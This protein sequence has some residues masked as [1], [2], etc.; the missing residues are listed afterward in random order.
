ME[1]LVQLEKHF[2]VVTTIK[3][4]GSFVCVCFFFGCS[5]ITNTAIVLLS[6]RMVCTGVDYLLDRPVVACAV[7]DTSA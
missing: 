3:V 4:R 7:V 2:V 6:L 1:L 5:V